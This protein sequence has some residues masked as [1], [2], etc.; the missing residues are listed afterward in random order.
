M[1]FTTRL[2]LL[3][4]VACSMAAAKSPPSSSSKNKAASTYSKASFVPPAAPTITKAGWPSAANHPSR[5]QQQ[6]ITGY[7]TELFGRKKNNAAASSSTK[8]AAV[9][10]V[11]KNGKIQIKML[12]SVPQ[13]GQAGDIVFV[14][15]AVFQNQLQRQKKARLISAEEVALIEA[16]KQQQEAEATQKAI[17]TKMMM[18]EAMLESIGEECSTDQDICGVALTMA[19]KA[20]PE[21]NLFGGINPKMIMDELANTFPD[22]SWEGK[23]VKL[24]D[25]K[26]SDGKDVKKKDIKHTGEYTCVVK[27]G[28]DVD[29]T[30]IL[31]VVAE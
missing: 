8:T 6:I 26:D 4:V 16:E 19:R 31:S 11:T 13:I 22:G 9:P 2:V 12:A 23:Q 25:M 15:S 28:N 5:I 21:G 18:E 20:G 14:S 1:N 29:V 27:L 30:F 24:T 10:P 7:G 17:D 3:A